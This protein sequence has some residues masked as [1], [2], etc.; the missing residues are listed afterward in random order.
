MSGDEDL[1]EV[2]RW[3]RTT[4][5]AEVAYREGDSRIEFRLENSPAPPMPECPFLAGRSP[6]VGVYRASALGSAGRLEK[7]RQVREGE[8]LGHIET[9]GVPEPVTA[10]ASGKLALVLVEDGKPVE[11]GQTLFFVRP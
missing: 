1:K 2:I 11:Y 8:A 5:L 6:A 10:P 7:G 9:G 4:D 3:A